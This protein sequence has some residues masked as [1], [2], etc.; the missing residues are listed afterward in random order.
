MAGE[1]LSHDG[2]RIL[3][4]A[5][6]A[7]QRLQDVLRIQRGTYGFARDYGFGGGDLVD[8]TITPDVQAR[9]FAAVADALSAPRNGLLDVRL[10]ELR[11]V[12]A[13]EG[14]AEVEVLAE[15][16]SAGGVVTPIGVRSQLAA[17]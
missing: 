12:P 11:I 6:S 5:E 7:A 14:G 17:A 13:A 8:V 10:R 3:V 2:S 15:W 16:E 4:G 1:V 9:F